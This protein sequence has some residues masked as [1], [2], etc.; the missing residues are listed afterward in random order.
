[1][2]KI[3]ML[4]LA[5]IGCSSNSITYKFSPVDF[6]RSKSGAVIF[7][8]YSYHNSNCNYVSL[9]VSKKTNSARDIIKVVV[10]TYINENVRQITPTYFENGDYMVMG[11]TCSSEYVVDHEANSLTGFKYWFSGFSVQ[12]SE[13]TYPGSILI[14][15]SRL[16]SRE[17]DKLSKIASDSN[18]KGEPLPLGKLPIFE[19]YK[20][21]DKSKIIK[22][23]YTGR[24][25]YSPFDFHDLKKS[26]FKREERNKKHFSD[27]KCFKESIPK[28]M[29]RLSFN[30]P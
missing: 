7:D 11:A 22:R 8:F 14:E 27:K 29:V 2:K 5:L 24:V 15:T 6:D 4:C 1:M 26:I 16:S 20:L 12:E 18:A 3:F 9:A 19:H 30:Q 23:N 17:R 10:P 25:I 28:F 21:E 13:V